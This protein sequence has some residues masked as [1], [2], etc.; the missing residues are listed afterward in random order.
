M[1]TTQR[2]TRWEM[3]DLRAD[4]RAALE[5]LLVASQQVRDSLTDAAAAL[6]I[7]R[8]HAENDGRVSDLFELIDPKPR[9]LALSLSFREL[10]KSR[11]ESQK[12]LFRML[13]LEGT[14]M[15]DIARQWGI[16]RQLVSRL[17]N[18]PD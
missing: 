10:E 15:S 13:F 18:E 4:Y 17:I 8:E 3:A 16:S 2:D 1:T 11:H 5:R 12:V 9:R 6:M 14:S 7:V